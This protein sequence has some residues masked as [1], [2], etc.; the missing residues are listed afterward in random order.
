MD[1]ELLL[2]SDIIQW[3]SKKMPSLKS[4]RYRNNCN[5]KTIVYST[6]GKNQTTKG[7][8]ELSPER[9]MVSNM[10]KGI[11]QPHVP[12]SS[13]GYFEYFFDDADNLLCSK[14][15]Y[16][17]GLQHFEQDEDHFLQNWNE[18]VSIYGLFSYCANCEPA[19]NWITVYIRRDQFIE[20]R[21]SIDA[22]NFPFCFS[23]QYYVYAEDTLLRMISEYQFIPVT[24]GQS[25][26]EHMVRRINQVD[27]FFI[28]REIK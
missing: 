12:T 4:L 11:L 8:Y 15:V 5:A 21:I 16:A 22:S 20:S 7:N 17:D 6:L 19:C 27:Y 1:K 28:Y 18:E 25:F 14:R 24:K 9:R 26:P 23:L 13:R 2:I 10:Q 3:F